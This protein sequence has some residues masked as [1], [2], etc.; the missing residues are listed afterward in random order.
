MVYYFKKRMHRGWINIINPF[1]GTIV[2]GTPGSGKSFGIIGNKIFMRAIQNRNIPHAS[3]L[4]TLMA[5]SV[6]IPLGLS[7]W[8]KKRQDMRDR[9]RLEE[10][11]ARLM[12]SAS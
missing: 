4:A 3:A 8:W 11:T 7:M 2:L 9:R 12:T 10:Q 1:R 6:L 5:V